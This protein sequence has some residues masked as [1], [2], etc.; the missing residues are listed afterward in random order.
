MAGDDA[1]LENMFTGAAVEGC[2]VRREIFYWRGWQ[3]G[4]LPV[5]LSCA[6]GEREKC[7]VFR[8]RSSCCGSG[9]SAVP[10]LQAGVFTGDAGVDGDVEY[11][12]SRA[13][14]D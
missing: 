9:I 2:A 12:L 1:G 13:A 8:F 6:H 10:A 14:P 4:V 5:D 3:H 7:A 11:G